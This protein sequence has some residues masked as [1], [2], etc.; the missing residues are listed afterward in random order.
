MT[1]RNH[2]ATLAAWAVIGY[3]IF[4]AFTTPAPPT[5]TPHNGPDLRAAFGQTDNPARARA[6]AA[7][8]AALCRSIA[9]VIEYDGRLDKPRLTT[10]AQLDRLRR[11]A[12]EYNLDGVSL[13]TRYPAL[14]PAIKTYLDEQL[15]T[16]AGPLAPA[17][18]QK[19]VAAYR[20]LAAAADA[21]K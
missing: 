19:W 7:T 17:H 3:A 13:G 11:W 6:D 8:F 16:D 21:A 18:R 1:R 15:G 10:G 9:D 14:P 12:R 5:P 20:T 2:I 4:R